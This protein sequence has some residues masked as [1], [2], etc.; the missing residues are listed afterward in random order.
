MSLTK[1]IND[2]VTQAMDALGDIKKAAVYTIVTKGT[3]DPLTD[4]QSDATVD[5]GLEVVHT[6]YKDT[7]I[8]GSKVQRKDSKILFQQGLLTTTPSNKDYV[9]IGGTKWEVVDWMADPAGVI[10]IV[11]LRS[12]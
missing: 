5:V 12:V 10:W 6:S 3:Y 2:A 11:Q 8:D 7:E 9:T 1:T 4:S